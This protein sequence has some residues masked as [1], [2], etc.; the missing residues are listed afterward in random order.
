MDED[1]LRQ[2]M[3][4]LEMQKTQIESISQQQQMIQ[5][6]IDEYNRAKETL[7]TFLE[8]DEGDEVLV[9]VG[10]NSYVFASVLS[11]TKSLVGIGSDVTVE[12][13]IPDALET[14]SERI[15]GLENKLEELNEKME[16]LEEESTELSQRVQREYQKMQAAQFQ[17]R[18]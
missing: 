15:E 14:L 13:P 6:S 16:S 5:Y 9:P 18:Q 3:A 10:G 4:K 7:E 12:K 2:S 11:N 8:T 17:G 1:D